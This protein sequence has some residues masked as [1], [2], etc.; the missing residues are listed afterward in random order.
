MKLL[1]KANYHLVL[2]IINSC[3]RTCPTF[4]C[5]VIDGIIPGSVY[6]DNQ[7]RPETILIGTN[8]GIYFI[9]GSDRNVEFNTMFLNYYR[10]CTKGDASRFTLFSPTSSWNHVIKELL[11]KE[12]SQMV[13]RKYFFNEKDET[14]K[15]QQLPDG[16]DL[17]VINEKMIDASSNFN[18]DY[19]SQYWNGV[20]NYLKYGIGYCVVHNE[21]VV[22]ECTSIFVSNQYAEI[23]I[24][25][26]EE[27]AGNGFAY[28]LGNTF[29]KK[30]FEEG[31][32][33]AWDCDKQ[34]VGSQKLASKLG[35]DRFEEYSIYIR[36]T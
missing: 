32:T 22:S 25:T 2:P 8:N 20:S 9:A 19:Y 29:I 34:N 24:V 33:P 4:A 27:Y 3:S 17:V 5:S 23:D 1:E 21:T 31:L 6:V 14:T 36:K 12:T 11:Q 35:F 26:Q 30:C 13:R 28:L 15:I 16:F 7:K 18:R 10:Q